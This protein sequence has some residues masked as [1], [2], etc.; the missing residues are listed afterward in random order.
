MCVSAALSSQGEVEVEPTIEEEPKVVWSAPQNFDSFEKELEEL[1]E[2][3][4]E[5]VRRKE[6]T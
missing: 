6:G 1:R 4:R 2:S 3:V 5:K